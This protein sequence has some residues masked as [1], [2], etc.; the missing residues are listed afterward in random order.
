[1]LYKKGLLVVCAVAALGLLMPAAASAQGE[2][3]RTFFTFSQPVTLPGITLAAGK[4]EFRVADTSDRHVIQVF[5]SGGTKLI[6]TLFAIP[7]MRSDRPANSEVRF[8]ETPSDMSPAI[9]SWWY[10]GMTTGHEFI[11]SREQARL[12]ARGNPQ[13]V[14]SGEGRVGDLTRVTSTGD[15]TKVTAVEAP[16]PMTLPARV[17]IGEVP[18]PPPPVTI[19]PPPAPTRPV[20][21][22]PEPR[23]ELP[24]SA[25]SWPV[26]VW[27]GL[28]LLMAGSLSH[29]LGRRRR[30][31]F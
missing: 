30:R 6:K 14:L 21:M 26:I 5:D 13:G 17:E 19:V 3:Q 20:V 7:A 31:A 11:Y 4:Y 24:H 28:V 12:L 22:A 8:L 23:K 15:E 18:P 10:I 16:P 2:S 25:S 29:S 27:V 9:Q 1:M